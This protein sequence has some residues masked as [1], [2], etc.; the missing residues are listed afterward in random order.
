MSGVGDRRQLRDRFLALVARLLARAFFR[1]VEV[2]GAPPTGGPVILA[3]SHL[4]GFVDPV[5]LLAHLGHLPRFLAKATL[6]DVPPAGPLLGFARAIPVQRRADAGDGTDNTSMFAAAVDALAEGGML[7]VFPEGTTHDDPSIRPIRTGVARIALQAAA[8]GVEGVRIVP[9]GIAY[10]DKVAVRGRALIQFGRP[11]DVVQPGALDGSGLP[12]HHH[13]RELT[14]RLEAAIRETTPDFTSDEDAVGLTKAA[15]VAL[16]PLGARP[17]SVPM[18]ESAA[19]A[20]RLVAAPR[21]D[22]DHVIDVVGRYHL[23]LGHVGLTDDQLVSNR[24]LRSLG[25]RTAWLAVLVVLL[26]PFALVGLFGNIVPAVLVVVAGLAPKAP[27]S[28][29]TVRLLVAALVFPVTWAIIAVWDVGAG[30]LSRVFRNLTFPL[31]PVLEA[32]FDGDRTGFW[33]GVAV[34]VAVPLFGFLALLFVERSLALVRDWLV[35]RVLLD[36]RG[37][38]AALRTRRA[39]VVAITLATA[40]EGAPTHG[41]SGVPPAGAPEA[42]PGPAPASAT[43]GEA[44]HGPPT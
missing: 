5:L 36:R 40:D 20:R 14:D 43:S 23:L 24:H 3:A 6:W 25:I 35:W 21:P 28:K 37:Q 1:T 15:D 30:W 33:P 26:A 13:V 16:R 42:V 29:G 17:G 18:A 41:A 7:A 22:V 27:V 31:D 9:V 11:L 2:E 38:L 19:L 12:E 10:E 8:A 32:A 44:G 4:N 39:D 34:F